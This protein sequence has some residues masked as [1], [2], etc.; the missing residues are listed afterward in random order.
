MIALGLNFLLG[1]LLICGMMLGLRLDQRLRGLRDSHADFA[2]AVEELDQA[3]LRT[4]ASLAALRERTEEARTELGA[5]I[6]QARLLTQRLDKLNADAGRLI[7]QPLPVT[8][9]VV[10]PAQTGAQT[11]SQPAARVVEA[12]ASPTAAPRAAPPRPAVRPS[13]EPVALRPLD[14]A[15]RPQ[16]RPPSQPSPRSR[17]T[18]DDDLFELGRDHEWRAPLG[19]VAG[20]RR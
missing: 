18:V 15:P 8:R 13:A 7:D 20:G 1:M 17:V 19:A 10:Q 11:A 9:P 2:K 6:D 14:R 16:P 12:P 4:E 5:R 3:A